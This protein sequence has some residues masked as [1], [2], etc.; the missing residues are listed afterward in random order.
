MSYGFRIKKA[1]G[2]TKLDSSMFGALFAE[3]LEVPANVGMYTKSYSNF[4]GLRL[5]GLG[6]ASKYI[7]YPN[8]VPTI[9]LDTRYQYGKFYLFVV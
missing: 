8:D 2:Q 3:V 9:T 6:S 7:S 5:I 4:K 1:N